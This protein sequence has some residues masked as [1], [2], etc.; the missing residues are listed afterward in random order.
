[1]EKQTIYITIAL[2]ATFSVFVE[3][4]IPGAK[5]ATGVIA[6]TTNG[7][8]RFLARDG[9]IQPAI[10]AIGGLPLRAAETVNRGIS[11]ASDAMSNGAQSM[12]R[13]AGNDGTIKMPGMQ[14]IRD[15]MPQ[16]MSSVGD[17]I[18]SAFS[19]K[20]DV[21]RNQAQRAIEAGNRLSGMMSNSVKSIGPQHRHRGHGN[22]GQRFND[23]DDRRNNNNNNDDNDDDNQRRRRRPFDEQESQFEEQQ[24]NQQEESEQDEDFSQRGQGFRPD[25]VMDD[26]EDSEDDGPS[27]KA[28]SDR[29]QQQQERGNRQR[30]GNNNQQRDSNG[31]EQNN[32]RQGRNGRQQ[33]QQQQGEQN[34]RRRGGRREQQQ[35]QSNGDEQQQQGRRNGRRQQNDDQQQGNNEQRFNRR[36][37]RRDF[38]Q[39]DQRQYQQNQEENNKDDSS[40]SQ[41]WTNYIN[42]N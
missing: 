23:Q 34:Q 21:I 1:M 25:L 24:D 33:Q 9:P 27:V 8:S 38:R 22:H 39:Q 10:T 31:M 26:D 4:Q 7:A 16:Q 32:E 41:D 11:S 30:R 18:S 14:T 36:G 19:Y 5:T 6:S 17:A 42:I 37:G 2:V 13:R 28:P 40:D 29:G 15:N 3:C 12:A 20:N 35:Q